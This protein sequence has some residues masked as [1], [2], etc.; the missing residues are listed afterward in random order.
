M[1]IVMG[2]TALC[3]IFSAWEKKSREHLHCHTGYS[4]VSD[5]QMLSDEDIPSIILWLTASLK[6]VNETHASF[7]Y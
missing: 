5:Q 4:C 6:Q 7:L 3:P 1:H 2:C